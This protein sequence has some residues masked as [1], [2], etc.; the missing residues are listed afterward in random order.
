MTLGAKVMILP[1]WRLGTPC[2][3]GKEVLKKG[4]KLWFAE[5]WGTEDF[6]NIWRVEYQL[7]RAALK[8]FNVNNTRDIW[9][10]LGGIWNYLTTEWFSLRL[11]DNDKVERRTV[12][13]W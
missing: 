2:G 13:P 1:S 4:T 5:V 11:P 12:H 3:K 7:R 6:S 10:K 9:K 8:Q